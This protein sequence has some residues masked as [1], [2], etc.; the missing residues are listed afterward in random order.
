[1]T[2]ITLAEAEREFVESIA[3]YEAK[4]AGLG[5]RFRNE[6]AETL[7]WISTYAEIPRLRAK[8]YRQV[9]LHVFPHYIA[10]VIRGGSG[11]WR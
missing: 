1:M 10:Y 8:G 11:S 2:V 5:M 3:Y 6:V 4:E 7:D 9:N